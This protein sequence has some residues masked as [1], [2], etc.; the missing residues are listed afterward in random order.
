MPEQDVERIKQLEAECEGMKGKISELIVS[1][2][3][4]DAELFD[5]TWKPRLKSLL[6]G[7]YLISEHG[8]SRLYISVKQVSADGSCRS[9]HIRFNECRVYT[10]GTAEVTSRGYRDGTDGWLWLESFKEISE[11]EYYGAVYRALM[12]MDSDLCGI[13]DMK[14]ALEFYAEKEN[15]PGAREESGIVPI[16]QITA[17]HGSL[18]RH[19]LEGV[20]DGK[21]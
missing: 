14:L 13:A 16:S 12:R 11:E 5:L 2:G 18:A 15:W 6:G 3:D 10:D 21:E 8:P 20:S 4:I 17:D 19:T 1:V 7:Y 9:S